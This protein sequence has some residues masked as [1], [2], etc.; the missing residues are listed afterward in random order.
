MINWDAADRQ[1]SI[2]VSEYVWN[3]QREETGR[4]SSPFRSAE[5]DGCDFS[6]AT[7]TV[8]ISA[9][10]KC[11]FVAIRRTGGLSGCDGRVQC[12]SHWGCLACRS[13][14]GPPCSRYVRTQMRISTSLLCICDGGD[15]PP[16]GNGTRFCK[17]WL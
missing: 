12:R 16:R 2:F 11:A 3:T 17:L 14:R 15:R 10:V 7:G 4:G 6:R 5:N 13:R 8:G 1:Y 9:S